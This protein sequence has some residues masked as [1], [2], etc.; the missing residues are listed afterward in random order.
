MMPVQVTIRDFPHSQAIESHI[1]KKAEKIHNLQHAN[2]CKIVVTIPQK[3][4]HQGK[5]YCVRIDLTV[6]GKEIV[7]N[8]QLDEDV[9]VAIRDAFNALSRQVK[10]HMHKRR[11]EVKT[12]PNEAR[13]VI[14][15]LFPKEG[16]GFIQELDG[17]EHYFSSSNI[18]GSDFDQ[19]KV[20]NA[21]TF[22]SVLAGDG[23]QANRVTV[24]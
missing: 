8:R 7:V 24:V 18:N 22:I 10:N 19:L 14:Q 12:H 20:G 1:R 21:V 4:K 5:L 16:Y 9:Y 23:M 11:G 15:K 13:G 17:S 3:H 2:H 6:P